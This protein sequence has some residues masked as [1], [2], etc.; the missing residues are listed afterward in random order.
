MDS[1]NKIKKQY[2]KPELTVH[3]DAKKLTWGTSGKR[4]DGTVGKTRN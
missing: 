3:G 4:G 2:S 1:K